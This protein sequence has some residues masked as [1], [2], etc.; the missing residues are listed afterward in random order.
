MKANLIMMISG[1]ILIPM[2]TS[3]RMKDKWRGTDAYAKDMVEL[4][5]KWLEEGDECD[6]AV[7]YKLLEQLDAPDDD[8]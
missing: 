6:R 3:V 2:V 7:A 5:A 1:Q 4:T 8:W